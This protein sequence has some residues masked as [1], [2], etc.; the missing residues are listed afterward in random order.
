[1]IDF[2]NDSLFK[3]NPCRP[4][5]ASPVVA[6][7]MLHGEQII[8]SYKTVRDLVVFTDKRVIAVNVQ[9]LTG[10][11]RDFTSLPY[12]K[13]QAWSVETAGTF[14]LDAELELWFSGLGK[15]RF[16]FKGRSDIIRLSHMIAGY[17]L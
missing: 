7:L 15:V 4:D 5:E 3:L 1:M 12:N 9:G 8:S 14:D 10:K 2:N 16:E 11:K 6:P 13:V 17:V